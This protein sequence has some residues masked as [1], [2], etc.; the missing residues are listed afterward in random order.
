VDTVTLVF[1][2]TVSG[3]AATLAADPESLRSAIAN[4]ANISATKIKNI[5]VTTNSS[6]TARRRLGIKPPVGTALDSAPDLH[7]NLAETTATIEFE[8]VADLSDEGFTD[9]D[10]FES[11]VTQSLTTSVDDGSL[12]TS[13]SDSCSCTATATTFTVESAANYPTLNPT[14]S[15]SPMPS[16]SPTPA[17]CSYTILGCGQTILDDNVNHGSFIGGPSGESNFL[18]AV[19]EPVRS[20]SVVPGN[21]CALSVFV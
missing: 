10:S 2:I 6:Q 15:P 19:Q 13:L 5:R 14:P 18:I 4:A 21:P 20:D 1:A 7:R 11:S 3:N 17:M 16:P 12:S 8:V 9:A